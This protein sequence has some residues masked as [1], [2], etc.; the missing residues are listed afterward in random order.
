M[1]TDVRM[2]RGR[3]ESIVGREVELEALL[4]SAAAAG[5]GSEA[6]MVLLSGD[7]GVGKTRLLTEALERLSAEGWRCLV[8]HC[9]DFGD[10]SVPY[11]PFAEVLAQV[12]EAD[13]DLAADGVHPALSRLRRQSGAEEPTESLD[14]AEVF[15]AVHALLDE[16]TA[17]TPVAL[18]VEDAHWADASTR[19]LISFLLS[20]RFR[21]RLLTVVTFRSDEMHRRHPLRQR[22]AEWVRAAGVERVQLDPL[23]PSAV[24][25]MVAGLV[26]G[27]SGPVGGEYDDDVTRIVQRAQ[28]NAFY[29]EELVS[30]FLSGG[31]SLPED[32][33]DLLLV[34]LDRLDEQSRDV[35]RVASAAGQ[36]VS[37]ELLA[38]VAPVDEDALEPA[39]RTAIDA[40]VL[41]RVGHG[42]YAFRHALLGEAVYDDLLPGERMRL[43][44]A[45][46]EA[47]RDLLGSRGAADL[48]RHA[49]A[50]HDLATA[51]QA[52]VEAGEMAMSSGGPDEAAGHFVKALEIYHRAAAGLADPPDEA[53]LVAR[54]VDA[55]CA[56]GRPETAL[57]LVNS[58]LSRLPPG[59]PDKSRARLLLAR[60]EALR[61]VESELRP[62]DITTEAL[63]LVGPEP[64]VLRARI[65]AMHAQAMIWDDRF[66]EARVVAGEAIALAEELG[67]PRLSADVGL[68]LTW[69]SQHVDFGEGSR[70]EL[71]RIIEEARERGDHLSEIRGHLRTGGVEMEYGDLTKAEEAF[72][73]A[74][75]VA[76]DIGRPWTMM[77]ISGRTQAA[78]VAFM[79]GDW[80]RALQI[81]DHSQED[82]RRPRARCSTR[83]SCS[84]PRAEAT[85]RPST[86]CRRCG[87]AG[88]GRE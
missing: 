20:R 3:T 86:C 83:S 57:S 17:R 43:H 76:T 68:T 19:D 34:R 44:T 48:A 6:R 11:L 23:P 61:S 64:S 56:A 15:E 71:K 42:E 55:L 30:A 29:V 2:E 39:L 36:R 4:R 77:G 67:Q 25:A 52:S 66:S 69:L 60:A 22:V 87:S 21:G 12:A 28:G 59:T 14:R 27:A 81:A 53:E 85:P 78:I 35:V 49:L 5:P 10:A 40:H 46:A 33:A 79:R 80:D 84:W 8:G 47:V 32:L 65:L 50:S 9:L 72:L 45:Y 70:A 63:A 38:R 54:T 31:W 74:S 1:M 18:V 82:P 73:T 88:T 37:H 7:A 41:V 16:L 58:H 51:L 13:P 26:D 75:R 62:S 24:R